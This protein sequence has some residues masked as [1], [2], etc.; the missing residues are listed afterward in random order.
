MDSRQSKLSTSLK[1]C[2]PDTPLLIAQHY[3]LRN[4][5]RPSSEPGETSRRSR[6]RIHDPIGQDGAAL[7]R[8]RGRVLT[9]VRKDAN[10]QEAEEASS[11]RRR[12]RW[13]QERWQGWQKGRKGK[14]EKIN[15][16]IPGATFITNPSCTLY[17][18]FHTSKF[19]FQSVF[20]YSIFFYIYFHNKTCVIFI[21]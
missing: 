10:W 2:F 7:L 6:Y 3:P 16:A 5:K 20:F 4:V 8:E 13:R 18:F 19:I 15:I 12:W 21:L 1:V 9:M 11:A 17:I 14:E